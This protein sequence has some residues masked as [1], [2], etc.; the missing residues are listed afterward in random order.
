MS[1]I[2]TFPAAFYA[3]PASVAKAPGG[4][5]SLPLPKLSAT[6]P[7]PRTPRPGNPSRSRALRPQKPSKFNEKAVHVADY[8]YRYYDPI[9]GR[10]P[11]RDPIEESGGVNLYGFVGNNSICNI[12]AKGLSAADAGGYP[13]FE[14]KYLD[15]V[16][17]WNPTKDGEI[18]WTGSTMTIDG[19]SARVGRTDIEFFPQVILAKGSSCCIDRVEIYQT[20]T[21]IL[22][23][24]GA[25][26]GYGGGGIDIDAKK[27][28]KAFKHEYLGH[29]VPNNVLAVSVWR[30]VNK[31]K[32][33]RLG[34]AGSCASKAKEIETRIQTEWGNAIDRVAQSFHNDVDYSSSNFKDLEQEK[35]DNFYRRLDIE[36]ITLEHTNFCP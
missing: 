36:S 4:R 17:K 19:I 29:A 22:P 23:A 26:F 24:I 12:D 18:G 10:W 6:S 2:L 3:E 31:C 14:I 16:P 9:T 35:L 21:I 28:L 15:G 5:A 25:H 7:S 33:K 34:N 8:L 27:R 32:G 1:D 11:S 20:Q 30:S 13:W